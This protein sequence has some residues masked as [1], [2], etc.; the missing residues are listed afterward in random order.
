MKPGRLEPDEIELMRRHPIYGASILEPSSALRPLVPIVRAHHE[1]FDGTGY[2]NGLKGEGIPLGARILLVSDAYEAMTSDRI[3]RKALG[4]DRAMEQLNKHKGRQFDPNAVRALDAL[5]RKQGASAFEVSD[6][7][8]IEYETL[9][10]LRRR[11]TQAR[12]GEAHAG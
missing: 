3:Y 5:L 2:P 6:L 9:A 7:P 12:S 10:E 8:P 1:N 4:H 11:L